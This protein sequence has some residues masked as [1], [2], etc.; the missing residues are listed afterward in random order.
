[1]LKIIWLI[2][3][4]HIWEKTIIL[5][6]IL[7]IIL[8]NSNHHLIQKEEIV[9]YCLKILKLKLIKIFHPRII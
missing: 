4:N 8:Y 9:S 3:N 2:K 1:M 6:H 5:I 7:I